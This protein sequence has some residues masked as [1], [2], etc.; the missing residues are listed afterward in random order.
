MLALE[1]VAT[2]CPYCGETIS[3]LIDCSIEYEEYIEDCSV[4]CRP[5]EIF[6]TV[7][8]DGTPTLTIKRDTD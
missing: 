7:G 4:C 8:T 3:L 6:S 2:S 1:T 5:I